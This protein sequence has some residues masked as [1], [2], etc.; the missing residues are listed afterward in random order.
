MLNRKLLLKILAVS[1]FS[2]N[3]IDDSAEALQST[4]LGREDFDDVDWEA[5]VSEL[6]QQ[7][8]LGITSEVLR[9]IFERNLKVNLAHGIEAERKK[10][11][12]RY[13]QMAVV[14]NELCERIRAQ[15]ITVAVIKGMA[16]ACYYPFPVLR[17]MGDIDLIVKPEE[18]AQAV[19]IL[20]ESGFIETSE[21]NEYHTSAK[22]ND[23]T[24]ELH[25]SP[26]SVHKDVHGEF[27]RDFIL[28]GLNAV[29][30]KTS[31][32]DSFPMLPWQQNGM[33]LI[34]HIRQH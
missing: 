18:Y 26:A 16:S 10:S 19:R 5:I 8:V 29:E 9:Q 13:T 17:K 6:K 31:G 21:T 1:L 3:V 15:G 25:R 28:S 27:I 22:R 2:G 20:K 34:W 23:I 32:I 11:I 7:E 24:V 12:M 33:E 30:I 14:Q 4:L